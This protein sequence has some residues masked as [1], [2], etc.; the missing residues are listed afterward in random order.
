MIDTKFSFNSLGTYQQQKEMVLKHAEWQT[1]DYLVLNSPPYIVRHD[2]II[3]LV[4]CFTIFSLIKN[5]NKRQTKK[6]NTHIHYRKFGKALQ[7]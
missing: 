2:Y 6:A 5:K 4:G 7:N 1:E 3:V